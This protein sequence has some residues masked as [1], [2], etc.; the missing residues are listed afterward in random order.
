MGPI[1]RCIDSLES[2]L[3]QVVCLERKPL[4]IEDENQQRAP[5]SFRIFSN[6]LSSSTYKGAMRFGAQI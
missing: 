4:Y 5:P 1:L 6:H 3:E 2:A